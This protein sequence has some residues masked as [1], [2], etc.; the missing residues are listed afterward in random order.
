MLVGLLCVDLSHALQSSDYHDCVAFGNYQ[1]RSSLLP[2]NDGSHVK[3]KD[4]QATKYLK[5]LTLFDNYYNAFKTC[6]IFFQ[7]F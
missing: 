1:G 7:K 3:L 6:K 2:K 4:Q 5:G